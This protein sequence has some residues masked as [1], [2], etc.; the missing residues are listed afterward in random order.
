[1]NDK[2]ETTPL[3]FPRTQPVD[4]A[5]FD[6]PEDQREA[7]YGLPK[8]VQFCKRCIISNQRPSSAVEFAHT[9]DS[10]KSTIQIDDEGVCDACRAALEDLQGILLANS[11]MPIKCLGFKTRVQAIL[12]KLRIDSENV[13]QFK[14]RTSCSGLIDPI[15]L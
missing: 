7:K 6:G 11:R 3:A 4:F 8:K 12:K 9:S 1:M 2:S 14:L 13:V 10:L 15:H 5:D